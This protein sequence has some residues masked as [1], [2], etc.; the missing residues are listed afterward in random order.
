MPDK[1]IEEHLPAPLLNEVTGEY[2][3]A[4]C[5]RPVKYVRF[6]DGARYEHD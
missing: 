5:P 4:H 2:V 6:S 3:C 1:E